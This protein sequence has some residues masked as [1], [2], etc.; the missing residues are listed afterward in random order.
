[1]KNKRTKKTSDKSIVGG[2]PC[3]IEPPSVHRCSIS[4]ITIDS[5]DESEKQKKTKKRNQSNGKSSS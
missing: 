1:M 5:N 2:S 4:P 3:R